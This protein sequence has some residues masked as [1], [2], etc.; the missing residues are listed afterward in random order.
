MTAATTTAVA[1]LLRIARDKYAAN[2]SHAP[3]G[4]SPEAGMLCVATAIMYALD[5]LPLRERP[6]M[7]DADAAFDAAIG[8]C[9][10]VD[11][12]ATHTTEEVLATFDKAI[13]IAE[14]W[15]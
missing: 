5:E 15:A 6:S 1:A 9:D 7:S 8:G 11:F 13:E 10:M 12:N 4:R 3:V 2:P 14:T